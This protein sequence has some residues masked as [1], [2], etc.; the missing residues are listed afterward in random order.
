MLLILIVFLGAS[1]KAGSASFW[2]DDS[3]RATRKDRKT[4][5]TYTNKQHI[6]SKESHKKGV[7]TT[8]TNTTVVTISKGK[9]TVVKTDTKKESWTHGKKKKKTK[10]KSYKK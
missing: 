8:V 2:E 10:N 4:I 3:V 1:V 6:Y 5:I 7:R 9:K